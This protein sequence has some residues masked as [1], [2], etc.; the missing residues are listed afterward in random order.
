M[1]WI[2]RNNILKNEEGEIIAIL[3]EELDVFTERTI[4]NSFEAVSAIRTFIEDADNNNL[5]PRATY[6]DFKKIIDRIDNV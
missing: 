6:N 2:L 3:P 1:R 5:K 4:E